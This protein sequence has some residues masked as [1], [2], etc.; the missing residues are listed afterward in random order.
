MKRLIIMV[1]V[2]GLFSCNNNDGQAGDTVTDTTRTD[3]GGVENV[4]GNIPDTTAMGAT[5]RS[6]NN[7]P[8]I[9]SSYADTAK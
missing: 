7:T 4:N 2:I 1:L 5:P 6:G 9:D 8:P 3:I